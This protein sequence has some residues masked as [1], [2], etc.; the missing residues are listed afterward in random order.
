MGTILAGDVRFADAMPGDRWRANRLLGVALDDAPLALFDLDDRGRGGGTTSCNGIGRKGAPGTGADTRRI[1]AGLRRITPTCTF[2]ERRFAGAR[3]T[4]RPASPF[5]RWLHRAHRMVEDEATALGHVEQHREAIERT[6]STDQALPVHQ[7][8][9]EHCS[10]TTPT[11][12]SREL[13]WA[14]GLLPAANRLFCH[15][16]IMP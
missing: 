3:C 13:N 10:F 12:E 6:N 15:H 5:A 11:V 8:N 4:R 2:I 7:E 1:R 16:R 9:L 14:A